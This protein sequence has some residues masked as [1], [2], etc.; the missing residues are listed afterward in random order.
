MKV[1]SNNDNNS[2]LVIVIMYNSLCNIN[3]VI[4]VSNNVKY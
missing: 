2:K 1:I 4:I 3:V